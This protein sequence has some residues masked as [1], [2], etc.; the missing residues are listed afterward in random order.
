MAQ[1]FNIDSKYHPNKP[2]SREYFGMC[3]IG[4]NW[5]PKNLPEYQKLYF[6]RAYAHRYQRNF[7]RCVARFKN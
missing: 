1:F 7:Q 3:W 6:K 5:F 2:L 4:I